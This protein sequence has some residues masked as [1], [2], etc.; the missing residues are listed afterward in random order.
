MSRE[1]GVHADL[2][3]SRGSRGEVSVS[4]GSGRDPDHGS[5]TDELLSQDIL[6]HWY[7]AS[8]STL[9]PVGRGRCRCIGG[10]GR[11]RAPPAHCP[12]G[13]LKSS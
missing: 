9:S 3:R 11:E 13:G 8:G 2:T 7:R 1:R 12:L 6:N 5:M 10:G 4:E